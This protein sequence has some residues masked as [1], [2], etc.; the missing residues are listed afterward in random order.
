LIDAL[1]YNLFDTDTLTGYTKGTVGAAE[2]GTISGGVQDN[3]DALFIFDSDRKT[4]L[5]DA[6]GSGTGF[7]VDVFSFSSTSED[8]VSSDLYVLL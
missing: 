4:L 3:V 2:F 8:L 5:V 7:A 6:D 1:A